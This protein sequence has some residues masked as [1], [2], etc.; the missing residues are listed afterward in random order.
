[1]ETFRD[2]SRD[3]A[4]GGPGTLARFWLRASGDL[5]GN[6]VAERCNAWRRSWTMSRS[7]LVVGVLTLA[8]AAAFCWLCL[9]TDETGILA[10]SAMI[11]AGLLG[12][13]H[14]RQ[15]WLAALILGLG[16]PL[17]QVLGHL[18]AW[19]VPYPNGPVPSP[20]HWG[21]VAG[22]CLALIFSTAGAAGG[23]IVGWLIRQAARRDG[24]LSA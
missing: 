15:A 3:A 10:C 19:P 2:A 13:A 12:L 9:H 6:A 24:G 11:L 8:G 14:P 17:A 16:A 20:N 4:R 7:G 1:V 21:D 23:A 5:L 18:F 22:A